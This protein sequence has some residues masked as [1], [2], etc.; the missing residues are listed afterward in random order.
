[1]NYLQ[2]LAEKEEGNNELNEHA[3]TKKSTIVGIKSQTYMSANADC[4]TQPSLV[5]SRLFILGHGE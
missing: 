3:R 2:F 5:F 4:Y 1:M